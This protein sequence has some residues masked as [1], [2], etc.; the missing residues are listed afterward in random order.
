MYTVPN[1]VSNPYAFE[2]NS[3]T[4]RQTPLGSP[5]LLSTSYMAQLAVL[6]KER[7]YF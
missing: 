2:S 6:I 5:L 7:A 4:T 1:Y 3:G